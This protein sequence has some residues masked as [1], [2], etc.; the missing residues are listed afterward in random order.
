MISRAALSIKN[1]FRVAFFTAVLISTALLGACNSNKNTSA[2]PAFPTASQA[3]PAQAI[4]QGAL[5]RLNAP[6]QP[7]SAAALLGK[8]IFF[9][10][11]LS[12]SG[13]LSCASCHVPG[14]A[15]SPT[16]DLS[17]QLG[18]IDGH[19]QGM[20]SAPTLTYAN[21]IPPFSIGKDLKPDDD[22]DPA[23]SSAANQQKAILEGLVPQGGMDWD[24]R[25]AN[26]AEQAGGPLMAAN[27]MANESLEKLTKKLAATPYAPD[28][29]LLFGPNVFN[30]PKLAVGEALFVLARFQLEERSFHP[31]NSKFDYYLA[32]K[33]KLS[34]QE[35]RGKSLFEDRKKGNCAA[36]HP[37]KASK[38]G[39]LAPTFTD[40]QYEALGAPRNTSITANQN[41][42]YYDEGLCGPARTDLAK[43]IKYCGMF[44][45]P[46]LRNVAT[47]RGFFH[48]G[49]FHSLEDVMHFYVEREIKPEKWYPTL[50]G[51]K[52]DKYN[53]IKLA[54]RKNVDILDAPFNRK[55][56][57]EL[58]LTEPE[59]KDVVAFLNTL[60][61]G[62]QPQ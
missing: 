61:D 2:N 57:D 36:C 32:G 40:Y 3:D 12:G 14:H 59:I 16:N 20:R 54:H 29:I 28:M 24:G 55:R 37:D 45:T 49:V 7:L 44:K 47:K 13:K 23:F 15:F 17:V 62:Y 10:E 58:A 1:V 50:A 60:T 41:S 53:D 56:G 4:T 31:Y 33:V 35:S 43:Q 48:N 39:R 18:G 19:T 34:E 30:V 11:S 38:D 25:A 52:V 21:R 5:A 27:E 8:K 51:G 42:H 26:Q 46:S 9:D 22:D 6:E